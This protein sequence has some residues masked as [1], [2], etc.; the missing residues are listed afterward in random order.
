[1]Q[2]LYAEIVCENIFEILFVPKRQKIASN[3]LRQYF[4]HVHDQYSDGEEEN[5]VINDGRW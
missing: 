1:M 2:S 4:Q 5:L 3:N